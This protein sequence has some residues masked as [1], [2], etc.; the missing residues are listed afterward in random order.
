[1]R[2][3]RLPE[4]GSVNV[5]RDRIT[6]SRR[7]LKLGAVLLGAGG[8]GQFFD[9]AKQHTL[10]HKG[11]YFSVVGPLNLE[12]SPQGQPVIVSFLETLGNEL[13]PVISVETSAW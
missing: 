12:R 1:V 9:P 3:F 8:P 13:V 4:I 11:E 7:T 5:E 10:D 6:M 2:P